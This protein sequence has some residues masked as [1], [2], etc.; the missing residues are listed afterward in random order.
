MLRFEDRAD[1][2]IATFAEVYNRPFWI[3]YVANFALVMGNALMYRFAELVAFLG[4]SER[5]AGAIVGTGLFGVLVVRLVMGQGIDRYGTRAA[6]V[7]STLLYTVGSVSFLACHS[8]SWGL[9]LAR[10]IFS[11]GVAGMFTC[12]I[13][14]IQNMVPLAPHRSDRHPRHKRLFGHDRRRQPG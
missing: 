9:Y 8:V 1:T 11:I 6:W 7:V 5:A 4:G 2:R 14:Q 10:T 12:S 3:A 13:V